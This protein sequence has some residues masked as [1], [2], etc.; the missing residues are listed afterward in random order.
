MANVLEQKD[1]DRILEMI[2]QEIKAKFEDAVH[3][4]EDLKK[5][6]PELLLYIRF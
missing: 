2:C 5:L 3:T 6:T 4:D 1:K